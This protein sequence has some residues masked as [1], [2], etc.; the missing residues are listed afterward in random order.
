VRK[1]SAA[2]GSAVFFPVVPGAVA[3]LIPWLL[4]RWQ[5]R[6]PLRSWAPLRAVGALLL[7]VALVT[8]IQALVRFVT[9]GRGTPLPLAAPD[10]LVV[11]GPYRYVRNPMYLTLLAALIGQGLVLWQRILFLYAA[12]VWLVV[13]AFVR[14][15]EEPTLS[16]RFGADYTAYRRAVPA[17]R[18]RLHPWN[19]GENS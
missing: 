6:R 5:L 15:Y 13:A 14:W 9:E 7:I 19:P 17:W 18:P 4:T 8:V 12:L 11:G 16:R 3:G 2:A 10:R 1:S